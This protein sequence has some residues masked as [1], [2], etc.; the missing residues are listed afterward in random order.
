MTDPDRPDPVTTFEWL[1]PNGVSH[2][3]IRGR[4]VT[5]GNRP[6]PDRPDPCDDCGQPHLGDC[7]VDVDVDW[8]HAEGARLSHPEWFDQQRPADF[9]D[10]ER[11]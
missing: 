2:Q 7:A 8:W 9:D 6:H 3:V 10:E 5:C 4:C 11:R 1:S